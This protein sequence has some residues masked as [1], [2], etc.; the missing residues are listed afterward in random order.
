MP[1]IWYA[2][3]R[4]FIPDVLGLAVLGSFALIYCFVSSLFRADV[5]YVAVRWSRWWFHVV[6][7]AVSMFLR[8]GGGSIVCCT[9]SLHD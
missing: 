2:V 5:L 9:A 4:L 7:C 8:V 6:C 1:T 3:P